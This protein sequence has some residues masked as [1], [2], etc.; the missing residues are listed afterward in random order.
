MTKQ[1]AIILGLLITIEIVTSCFD[2]CDRYKYFDFD[3]ISITP[4][5]PIVA[6]DDSLTLRIDKPDGRFIA[7]R[8]R[9]NMITT[10]Y[11]AVDCDKGWG[12]FKFP[13]SKIKV[14]SDSDY[15]DNL[16]ANSILNE[17]VIIRKWKTGNEY[18][19]TNLYDIDGGDSWSWMYISERPTLSKL[20]RFTIKLYKS[21][22]DIIIG[23]SDQI[24]WE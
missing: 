2:H 22:G 9:L 6:V 19:L 12:G 21:N 23:T 4:M 16:P 13:I 24:Q 17:I 18:E 5:N 20:H 14:T 1:I 10:A 3:S 7:A 15:S 11:A 8:I